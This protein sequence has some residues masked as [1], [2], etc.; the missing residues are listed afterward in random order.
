MCHYRHKIA[1]QP[2]AKKTVI[3]ASDPDHLFFP[4]FDK[5]IEDAFKYLLLIY[6]LELSTKTTD[7]IS[8]VSQPKKH[9]YCLRYALMAHQLLYYRANA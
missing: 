7:K 2:T 1:T 5:S 9:F 6:F 4:T 3:T 8:C